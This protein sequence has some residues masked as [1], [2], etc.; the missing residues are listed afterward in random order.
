MNNSQACGLSKRNASHH[1]SLRWVTLAALVLMCLV[2]G[3]AY[4]WDREY[5]RR[6]Y[7]EADRVAYKHP[8]GFGEFVR[9]GPNRWSEHNPDGAFSFEERYRY[10]G[11]VQLYDVTRDIWIVLDLSRH[12]IHVSQGGAPFG[13]LYPIISDAG[14]PRSRSYRHDEVRPDGRGYRQP[15][16]AAGRS[17][18]RVYYS[19]PNGGGEFFRVGSKKW[20]ERNPDGVFWF[21]ERGRNNGRVEL[22]DRTRDV[23][24]LIDPG[25]RSIRL[26]Q[27]GAPYQYLYATLSYY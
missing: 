1:S 2:S 6:Q 16:R 22:Y 7:F 21:D 26:S 9:L 3:S 5:D 15:T 27:S 17:F 20:I 4:A 24:I 8:Y 12:A 14:E 10:R 19:H 25:H 23:R 18:E 13:Y 11:A